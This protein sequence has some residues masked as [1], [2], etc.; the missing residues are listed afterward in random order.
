ML[1][2]GALKPGKDAE[3]FDINFRIV[4]DEFPSYLAHMVE[5]SLN[6]T[7]LWAFANGYMAY[8]IMPDGT[9]EWRPTKKRFKP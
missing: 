3:S 7:E 5:H 4:A 2:R 8:T 9:L 1:N 6:E